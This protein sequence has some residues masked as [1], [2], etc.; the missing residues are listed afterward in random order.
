MKVPN[1]NNVK[2]FP[3]IL[4]EFEFEDV[5]RLLELNK[6]LKNTVNNRDM[7]PYKNAILRGTVVLIVAR[8][9]NFVEALFEWASENI[10]YNLDNTELNHFYK[11][12]SRKFN[13][14][15][16]EN[17]N[18]LF[19]SIGI[20]NI[21]DRIYAEPKKNKILVNRLNELINKR[22]DIAHGKIGGMLRANKKFAATTKQVVF[23]SDFAV[24]FMYLLEKTVS[25]IL[26]EE[27]NISL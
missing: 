19:L 10:F 3:T 21:L 25:E 18:K 23:W 8:I 12:S 2:F 22:H 16:S 15:N 1:R 17:I 26:I 24:Q 20:Y 13:N 11:I 7:R 5:D 14:P 27:K 9:E 6:D 4:H